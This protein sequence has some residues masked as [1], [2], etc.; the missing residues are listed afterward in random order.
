MAVSQNRKQVAELKSL[1][2]K[3]NIAVRR[4][5]YAIAVEAC[6]EIIALDARV[7]SLNIMACLYH[8]DLGEAYLKL[9][10]YEKAVASLHT[11]REGLIEYRATK[12]LKFPDDW[13]NE[14]KAIEKLIQRIE[15]T[16]FR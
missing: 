16:H 4:K 13:L 11:A 10:E 1:R 14:L 7:K 6:L 3:L 12:K 5:E 2:E 8:K 9:L 15:A